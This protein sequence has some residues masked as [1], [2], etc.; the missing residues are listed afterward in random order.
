MSSPQQTISAY[1]NDRLVRLASLQ[2]N[3]NTASG[4]DI[5]GLYIPYDNVNYIS[6]NN[7]VA[8]NISVIDEKLYSVA[9]TY[10][11][12]ATVNSTLAGVLNSASISTLNAIASSLNNDENFAANYLSS[13]AGISLVAKT[14]ETDLSGLVYAEIDRAQAFD[15]QLIT[16]LSGELVRAI[17]AEA[18]LR[19][20]L[21]GEIVRATETDVALLS[22]ITQ[23]IVDRIAQFSDFSSNTDQLVTDISGEFNVTIQAEAARAIAAEQKLQ[24]DLSGEILRSVSEDISYRADLSGEIVRAIAAE[25]QLRLDLSGEELRA[26]ESESSLTQRLS[27]IIENYLT[28][29]SVQY[30]TDAH[31]VTTGNLNMATHKIVGAA[32]PTEDGDAT[33]KKYV[34]DEV[35]KLG[36]VFEYV[37]TVT[38]S[39][40][41][42]LTTLAKKE[43]GDVY[44]VVGSG[45]VVTEWI[46]GGTGGGGGA[47]GVGGDSTL[48]EVKHF[49]T[50]GSYLFLINSPSNTGT[51][52]LDNG[53]NDFSTNLLTQ[54]STVEVTPGTEESPFVFNLDSRIYQQ[55][56][57]Y[58][59][60]FISSGYITLPNYDGDLTLQVQENDILMLRIDDWKRDQF[61][62]R[63][64]LTDENGIY[65]THTI[66]Y[67]PLLLFHKLPTILTAGATA[68]DGE[69]INLIDITLSP[70]SYYREYTAGYF[71]IAP[72]KFYYT[73]YFNSSIANQAIVYSPNNTIYFTQFDLSQMIFGGSLTLPTTTSSAPYDFTDAAN[74]TNYE[75]QYQTYYIVFASDG[76]IKV[77]YDN[78]TQTIQVSAGNTMIFYPYNN[79]IYFIGVFASHSFVTSP[80]ASPAEALTRYIFTTNVITKSYFLTIPSSGWITLYNTESTGGGGVENV[81]RAIFAKNGDFVIVKKAPGIDEITWDRINNTDT[82]I[83]GTENRFTVT[84]NGFDGY[85]VNIASTYAGQNTLTTVGTVTTGEWQATTVATTYGG[86]S[87]TTYS[88]GDLLVGNGGAGLSKI[89]IDKQKA[90]LRSTGSGVEYVVDATNEYSLADQ[91]NFAATNFQGALD[92]LADLYQKRKVV[93]YLTG[94]ASTYN[95]FAPF[96]KNLLSGKVIFLDYANTNIYIPPPTLLT[97]SYP[98]CANM[99]IPNQDDIDACSK[100]LQILYQNPSAV[101][102]P[103]ATWYNLIID[104]TYDG[105]SYN[106]RVTNVKFEDENG[107]LVDAADRRVFFWGSS[108]AKYLHFTYEGQDYRVAIVTEETMKPLPDGT[109]IRLVHN[110]EYTDSNMTVYYHHRINETEIPVVELAP[111]DTITLVLDSATKEWLVGVG[112]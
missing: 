30:G 61:G 51:A 104:L 77:P 3:L 71:R 89:S 53:F 59:I 21:S 68:T 12:L 8:S 10:A 74:L 88:A 28:K 83:V 100:W 94:S 62:N 67:D 102:D 19:Q 34:D 66:L 95:S 69:S 23:T 32:A 44:K 42:D 63:I 58:P 57:Y 85:E 36:S 75:N 108:T 40:N 81:A 99:R 112:L 84:G 1:V 47:P 90:F 110:G 33:N 54:V 7:T 93:Q 105:I 48:G 80:V 55:Y 103:Y 41:N 39:E 29:T 92:E 64:E 35:N 49:E 82:S 76:Y 70:G 22:S 5:S 6:G 73:Y 86:T 17:A 107:S 14:N 91:T 25:S 18:V 4:L 109:M 16:D 65:Y 50:G 87:H 9:T 52:L 37:D 27:T 79:T 78:S 11:P 26:K 111:H 98:W 101:C 96:N 13:I 97:N 45:P 46:T 31:I 72:K 24:T 43:A 38:I 2:T 20:D 56:N 15:A 106:D 60:K